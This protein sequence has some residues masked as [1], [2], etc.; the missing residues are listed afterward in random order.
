MINKVEEIMAKTESW[1]WPKPKLS[2]VEIIG[3]AIMEIF[4]ISHKNKKLL[5]QIS[6]WIKANKKW[7]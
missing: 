6:N 4:P 7:N 2:K 3:K 1:L 5:S